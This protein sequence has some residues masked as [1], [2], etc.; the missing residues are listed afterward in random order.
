M[1]DNKSFRLSS[2]G[3]QNVGIGHKTDNFTLVVGDKSYKCNKFFVDFIS[4]KIAEIHLIDPLLDTFQLDIPDP[5]GYFSILLDLMN[6]KPIKLQTEHLEF[7]KKAA[8]ALGNNEL[9]LKLL[10]IPNENINYR[11]ALSVLEEKLPYGLDVTNEINIIASSFY[12]IKSKLLEDLDI[13]ILMRIL[14][15]PNLVIESERKLFKFVKRIIENNE[16]GQVLL[17]SINY[18]QLPDEDMEQF[19]KI[20]QF[21]ESKTLL[22]NSFQSRLLLECKVVQQ[23]TRY[24]K[25]IAKCLYV[26]DKMFDGIFNY[27]RKLNKGVNPIDCGAVSAKVQVSEC[28]IKIRELFERDTHPRWYLTEKDNNFLQFDFINGKVSMNGYSWGSGSESSYWEFPV[29][30]TW[31]GSEDNE[32]WTPIDIKDNNEEMGGNEKT[33]HWDCEKSPFFR[34]IRFRLRNVQRRGGLYSTQLELFGF[35]EEPK[36]QNPNK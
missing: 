30:Y 33:H 9:L 4:P 6:G 2:L 22:W 26:E 34:Y 14:N 36:E 7:L 20:V 25:K 18:T 23:K 32:N 5:N 15:S 27:I 1:S 8:H 3:L 35:Y 13:D 12:N 10:D 31:E 16:E 21:D 19:G 29:S 17:S 24:N 11:N 28:T